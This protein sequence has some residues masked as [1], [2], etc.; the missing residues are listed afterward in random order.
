VSGSSIVLLAS[1]LIVAG[2]MGPR[3]A[4][5]ADGIERRHW[6][7]GALVVLTS[8]TTGSTCTHRVAGYGFTSRR[9]GGLAMAFRCGDVRRWSVVGRYERFRRPYR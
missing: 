9:G 4:C 3:A 2:A 8:G 5:S 1:S 7:F 6:H